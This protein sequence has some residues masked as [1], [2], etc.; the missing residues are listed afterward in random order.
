MIP[1]NYRCD[2][3]MSIFDYL[4]QKQPSVTEKGADDEQTNT[5]RGCA[6]TSYQTWKHNEH[7]SNSEIRMHP[8]VGKDFQLPK[9]GV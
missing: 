6:C 1:D 3:Q 8:V 5:D 2:G 9:E 7:R 4:P